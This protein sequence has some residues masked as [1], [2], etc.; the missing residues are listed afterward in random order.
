MAS[1][2]DSPDLTGVTLRRGRAA[3]RVAGA[4]VA[5]ALVIGVLTGMYRALNNRPD[6][7]PLR[8]EV[9]YTWEHGGTAPGTAMFG[10]LPT[11]TFCLLP[12]MTWLPLPVGA[13]LYV[14]SNVLAALGAIYMLRRW[15][16]PELP[17]GAIVWPVL[18]ASPNI[19]HAIQANQL[20]LWT[21]V[22]CVV[23]LALVERR[24]G[25]T[26][27][28]LLGLAALIKTM[29]A[30]LAG[31]LLLRRRWRALAGMVL[32]FVL[33]DAAPSVAMFGVGGAI[34][35]HRAWLRRSEWHSNRHLIEQPLL[36]AHRHGHNSSLS[37]V[38]TR[39]LRSV[40]DADEQVILYGDVPAEEIALARAELT[41]RQVLTVD[42]MPPREGGWARLL[43]DI[44]WVP[45]FHVAD[46]PAE[47][48]YGIWLG[49]LLCGLVTLAVA[50]GLTRGRAENWAPVAAM[51]LLATFWPSPMARHYYLAWALPG[52]VVVW[53]AL[54]RARGREPQCWTWG[55][56]LAV[57]A[58]VAW[59]IGDICL[60]WHL[61][62]WYGIHLAAIGVLMAATAWAWRIG[63]PAP[64][65]ALEAS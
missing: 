50:T 40:P 2:S 21:L 41:P 26:G 3:R 37:A 65:A 34:D 57:A 10:Y 18:V 47:V 38:L 52:V 1:M 53:A 64:L 61:V 62:R 22:L 55:M 46:L 25:L 49:I 14:L 16:V 43:Y 12:F 7:Q 31:Y 32:A 27:G 44:R 60:G 29:P 23:G 5:L 42:P 54:V 56:R 28:L 24:R 58:V 8:D 63:R 33:F 30:L 15:W 51:W 13:S 36:R 48:V 35:E 19:A 17:A 4:V 11:T 59:V 39:W 20:T 6:W 45:R 9:R